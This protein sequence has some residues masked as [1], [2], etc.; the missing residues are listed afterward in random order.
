MGEPRWRAPA[1][2]GA[3][4]LLA[5]RVGYGVG[6]MLAPER[7]TRAWLGADAQRPAAQV[8]LR[9]LGARELAL[10]GAALVAA[11]K[12]RPVRGWLAVSAAGDVAD[13][14]ATAVG[15]S[16]LPAGA[17]R[18]TLVVAGASALASGAVATALGE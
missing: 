11:R 3:M 5:V 1:R 9:G 8:A 2:A 10:H 15:R 18:K 17:A 7:V 16:G 13:I 12:G 14:A 4:A 6:L